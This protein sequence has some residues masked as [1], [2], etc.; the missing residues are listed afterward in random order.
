[1][2]LFANEARAKLAALDKSQAV[3]EFKLD[4]TIITANENFLNVMGY[5]LDEIAGRHHGL[6]VDAATRDSSEYRG[7]WASLGRGE[8]HSAEF[9]RI[10]KGGREVWIQATYNPI[11]RDGKP[12]K[13][14]KFATDITR[15]KLH[16]ADFEGQ[17]R[18][19]NR[20]QAVITFA[21][22][23]TIL[24]ANDNFLDAMGYRLDEIK[25]KHHSLFVD[26]ATRDSDDYR[27]FWESLARG[28]FHAAEFQRVGK[29]GK[30]V[31]IQ[32]TYNPILDMNGRPFKVVK[33]ATDISAQVHERRR[34]AEAQRIIDA[35]LSEITDAVS[36]TSRQAVDGA[37][38]STQV[39][40]N[41]QSVAAGAEELAASVNEIS[42]QMTQAR[43]I[44]EQAV[45]QA[46]DTGGVVA[47]LQAAAQRIGEV[48]TLIESIAAQT[49]LLA[50]N[51]TI[52]AA[53]AGEAGRGF[54]VVAAEVK[55]LATQTAKA[56]EE[57]GAHIAETQATTGKAAGAIGTI[58]ETIARLNQISAAV[59]SAVEEQSA[60]TQE[61]STNMQSAAAGVATLSASMSDIADA[62]RLI[63]QATRKV[64][65]ASRA[66][67]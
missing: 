26:A 61:M 13:V 34:R 47:G 33:F 10:A 45:Q 1:M 19:I 25:G 9:K 31:W 16:N 54:A 17:I 49:N 57:I 3:I 27:A 63:D 67:A 52:E 44:A 39:S 21:L 6:F 37:G 64:R 42:Q 24:D 53:R 23:G 8:H 58:G 38:T 59:A 11:L 60:V 12:F 32:A 14:V 28:E 62:T 66:L 40:S 50:L 43:S 22:D 35:D 65:E 55:S 41:V 4:G 18:A 51:A 29:G 36:R 20:A 15:A 48:V 30:E 46:T 2:L 7:F 5:R 56:T